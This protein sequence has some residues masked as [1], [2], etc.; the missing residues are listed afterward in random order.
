MMRMFARGRSTVPAQGMQA[1]PAYLAGLLPD[2]C[3]AALDLRAPG[4]RRR[5]G[6]RDGPGRGARRG[7]RHRRLDR[8]PAA[9]PAPRPAAGARGHDRLPRRAGAPRRLRDAAAGRR[10]R[11]RSRTPSC[12]PRPPRST[13]R[14]AG[15]WCPR[16]WCTGRC[17]TTPTA[18]RCARRSPGCT[19]RHVL[20]GA[21]R[22]LRPAARA[23][24]H[25]G[26]A[27]ADEAGAARRWWRARVRRRGPPR[28]Q[29]VAGRARLGAPCRHRR[30]RRP[31]S[32]PHDRSPATHALDTVLDRTVV[33]GY[34][35]IGYRL[36]RR[37]WAADDPRPGALRGRTVVVTGAS[38]GLGK[39]AA[40][41]MARLGATVHLVV[42]DL[43]KGRRRRH[44]DPRR[45][46]RRRAAAAPVRRVR[47]GLGARLR[48]RPARVGRP[49]RR[50][51][52]QRG[53]PAARAAG[54]RG[55][56]RGRARHPRARAGC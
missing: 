21:G 54:D 15:P 44:R 56:A 26:S 40:A 47:P 50:T 35:K 22:D 17:R 19:D 18:R 48:G 30:A 39:A 9:A 20:V 25:A 4:G 24:G 34:T 5:R 43:Q 29:L 14:R 46:A 13:P 12:S 6:H 37:T 38:S 33:P 51:R 28:H 36:R 41:A 23:A 42:R 2:G 27:P 8:L 45:G 49:G 31:G 11:H 32:L 3:R 16:R 52:A 55:R 7:R 10:A 1:L 53:R